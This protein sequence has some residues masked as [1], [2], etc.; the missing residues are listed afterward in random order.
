MAVPGLTTIKS[1]HP[2]RETM[3]RLE[4]AVKARA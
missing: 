4:A 3:D 1:G 2:A